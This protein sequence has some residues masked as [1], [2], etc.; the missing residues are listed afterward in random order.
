MM[1]ILEM[2]LQVGANDASIYVSIRTQQYFRHYDIN[3]VISIS[4]NPIGQAIVEQSNRTLKEMFIEQER[5]MGFPKN[6]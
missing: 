3:C 2:S 6:I 1:A 4:H 5:D